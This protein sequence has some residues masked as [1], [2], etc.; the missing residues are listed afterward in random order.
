MEAAMPAHD[1]AAFPVLAHADDLPALFRALTTPTE[2]A[3]S[4]SEPVAL[5]HRPS[6]KRVRTPRWRARLAAAS[7]RPPHRQSRQC[8]IPRRWQQLAVSP[9][10]LVEA[11]RQPPARQ[12]APDAA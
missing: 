7:A 11:P 6:E 10:R 2:L 1:D 4:F 8:R 9:M 5:R 12:P 3:R